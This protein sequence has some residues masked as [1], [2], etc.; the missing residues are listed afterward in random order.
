M[1]D[2]NN[3]YNN[4]T[5]FYNVNDDNFKEFMAKFYEDVL[6]NHRDVKYIKEHL[7]EEIKNQINNYLQNGSFN[8]D[9]EQKV[10]D[11]IEANISTQLDS[12]KNEIGYLKNKKIVMLGDSIMDICNV[13][14]NVASLSG[15]SVDN[16]GFQGCTMQYMDTNY[17]GT[18]EFSG[19]AIS[20]A[21]SKNDF[22]DQNTAITNNSNLSMFSNRLTTLKNIDFSKID[23]VTVAYGTNDF[24]F[25]GMLGNKDTDGYNNVAGAIKE[26]VKNLQSVNNKME[27][28]F[29]TPIYRADKT[30]NNTNVLEDY[31]S[32]IKETASSLGIKVID[33]F[34]CSGI[35]QFNYTT[36]LKNDKLHPNDTGSVVEANAIIKY[37]K[38][39]YVG[40]TEEEFQ[41]A[42][43]MVIDN[44]NLTKHHINN[45]VCIVNNKKFLTHAKTDYLRY[46]DLYLVDGYYYLKKLDT[47]VIDFDYIDNSDTNA[48]LD[49][50]VY[51]TSNNKIVEKYTT[52]AKSQ[53]E[54]HNHLE[55]TL[56]GFTPDVYRLYVGIKA[57]AVDNYIYVRN[58]NVEKKEY[59]NKVMYGSATVDITEDN[60]LYTTCRKIYTNYNEWGEEVIPYVVANCTDREIIVSVVPY[61]NHVD[62]IIEKKDGT[63]LTKDKTYKCNFIAVVPI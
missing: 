41:K 62:M 29:F 11:Y 31:V 16:V 37:A 53:I 2:L 55:I 36:L 58:I 21:I 39:G 51:N 42:N 18:K 22:G 59:K 50:V 13:P 44:E 27:I 15:A 57:M 30:A 5:N 1:A 26:I 46:K 48:R 38:S 14:E 12:I 43:T 52:L 20:K 4:L 7:H 32:V 45:R 25:N 9:I 33:L 54:T 17:V 63:A 56:N 23:I 28:I 3:L 47:I 10:N 19:Y 35:N 60:Q 40:K 34:T 49:V 6:T 8:V 24:G 61:W